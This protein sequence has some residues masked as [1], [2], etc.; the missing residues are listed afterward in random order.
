AYALQKQLEYEADPT[1]WDQGVFRPMAQTLADLVAEARATDFAAFI[2]AS[3]DLAEIR[4]ERR[5]IVRDNV[6][7]ELGLF[8]GSLGADRCFIVAPRNADPLHLPSD[9]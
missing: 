8:I 1:V 9:L 4:G 2:F 7:F 6:L 3:D 5:N